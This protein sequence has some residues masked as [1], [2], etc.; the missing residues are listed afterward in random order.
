MKEIIAIITDS[1]CTIYLIHNNQKVIEN[2][3]H[4]EDIIQKLTQIIG[5]GATGDA[6]KVRIQT[7]RLIRTLKQTK[8]PLAEQLHNIVFSQHQ[9]D[10]NNRPI[11]KVKD[12]GLSYPV[13]VDNESGADLLLVED[14]VLIPHK[15]I[16]TPELEQQL[17]W[18]I[19][20]RKNVNK[21]TS[22]GLVPSRTVLFTGAPGVG[23]TI[24]AKMIAS[25][26]K[27]PLL[28]LDL[29]TVIS[30]YLGRTGNNLKSALDYARNRPCV[31]LLDEIDAIAKHRD[32]T[33][34]IG[35]LK[36]LVTVMLQELDLW[37]QENLLI[38]ATNHTQ[39]LDAAVQRRFDKVIPFP[40]PR[41]AELKKVGLSLISKSDNFPRKWI[42]SLSVFMDGISYSDF[43]RETNYLRKT[44]I[45]N[46]KDAAEQ[47]MI[48]LAQSHFND[49]EL[50]TKKD[51]A[52]K[53]MKDLRLSQRAVSKM[54][55]LHRN[56]LRNATR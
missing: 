44:Y 40:F 32:D 6:E 18:L 55:G 2:M 7:M 26:L 52:L 17:T 30:S 20:E 9:N 12:Y 5:V 10:S 3:E 49:I 36:R 1:H 54:T 51:I 53:L 46:G 56:T 29:A 37:P 45:I 50:Q 41:S 24:A 22:I 35:E 23:K 48:Q 38:A 33:A 15:I 27:L 21:L 43:V 39:L 31:L 13:P 19:D 28:T 11:R 8:D 34:D 47:A 4:Q 25:I 42:S 16:L 14:P